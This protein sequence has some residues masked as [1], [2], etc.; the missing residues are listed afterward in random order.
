M[1]LLVVLVALSLENGEGAVTLL[2]RLKESGLG[3]LCASIKKLPFQFWR[4]LCVCVGG[5]GGGDLDNDAMHADQGTSIRTATQQ[6]PFSCRNVLCLVMVGGGGTFMVQC[7][8]I[9]EFMEP[10]NN[11]RK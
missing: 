2:Q 1:H 7:M 5:G 4:V 10:R 3:L 6:P 11:D 8:V 9:K